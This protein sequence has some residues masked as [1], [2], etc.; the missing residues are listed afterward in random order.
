MECRP[1]QLS[2]ADG[3][4][5]TQNEPALG[6]RSK[7]SKSL[8]FT[9]HRC[10]MRTDGYAP[11]RLATD[12]GSLILLHAVARDDRQQRAVSNSARLIGT[13]FQHPTQPI[14][15]TTTQVCSEGKP[16]HPMA[17]ARTTVLR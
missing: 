1:Y 16:C 13:R 4:A 17:V 8:S 7:G 2:R 9:T 3:Q 12:R 11:C 6:L 10:A 5:D 14:A 15:D